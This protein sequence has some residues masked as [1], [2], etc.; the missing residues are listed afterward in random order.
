[1]LCHAMFCKKNAINYLRLY[2]A[3]LLSLPLSLSL[4]LLLSLLR[5]HGFCCC[6]F[7]CSGHGSQSLGHRAPHTHT[8]TYIYI[9]IMREARESI[10]KLSL[11]SVVL[12]KS[13]GMEKA[14]PSQSNN[15][16]K[17]T[18]RTVD[19]VFDRT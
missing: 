14:C 19:M 12:S 16:F 7:C 15:Q 4:L 13:Q 6:C 18:G 1:M 8:H 2:L 9:Y 11:H 3:M 17:T 10:D 5:C